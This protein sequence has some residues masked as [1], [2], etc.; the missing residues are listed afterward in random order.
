MT[1]SA[2]VAASSASTNTSSVPTGNSGFFH[3]NINSTPGG[4]PAPAVGVN[5]GSGG[6]AGGGAGV[7]NGWQGAYIDAQYEQFKADPASVAPDVRAFF[8]GFELAGSGGALPATG[9][10]SGDGAASRFQAAVDALVAAYRRLGHIGAKLDP[11]GRERARPESLSVAY[12][13]L[14]E[15]D[16]DQPVDVSLTGVPGKQATLREMVAH[17]EET[18]CG[19]LGV[20][21][22][23]IQ[24][25]AER[26]WFLKKFEGG[27]GQRKLEHD[28]KV[29]VLEE[30]SRAEGFER[31]LAKRYPTEKRF[32]L[33]GAESVI[34]LL[35]R[36]LEHSTTLGVEEVVIGM[37]HRGRLNVLNN[38]LGKSYEQIF[39]EFED[40]WSAGFADGG[41]DVKYHRG[42]SGERTFA[43]GAKLHVA[44]ASN[45][46][47]LESVDPV[48]CGRCR[49][50]QRLRGDFE[51]RRVIPL[52]IH[53]D[54]AIAGQGVVAECLNFGQ[55]EGYTV[56][57]TVHVVINNLIGFTT[58]P[59]D[60]R[61]TRYCTDVAKMIDAPVLHVNGEDPE[62]CIAAAE[63]AIEYRQMFRRDVMIDVWCYRKYGHNE[64]DEPSFTQPILAGL[65]RSKPSTLTRYAEGLAREGVV[66]AAEVEA[67]Q[68]RIEGELDEAQGKAKKKPFDPT[69]DPGS[70]RWAGIQGKYSFAPAKT[71][72]KAEV[73]REVCGA[74]GRTPEGF[75][76]NTKL[77]GL[78][79][80]R[81][82]LGEKGIISYADAEV[83]AIGTLLLEGIPV[84][85]SGQDC[86][87][88]TFT[89]RHA[90]LRDAETGVAYVPLNHMREVGQPGTD[91]PIGSAGSDGK[92][93]QARFCVYDSPLSEESVMGFDYG[94][95]L[96]D[97]NM[98]VCWE[99]QFGDFV[100]GAQVVI[101]QYL[102][103]SEA[104][105]D[106][107]SGLVLL[108]PH[109]YEGAGPEHSSGRLERF[110]A[111]C[112]DENMEVINPTTG[113][114]IFHALRRQVKRNFRK[115]LIVMT[116]KSLLR[117]ETSSVEELMSGSFQEV[118][119][120]PKFTGAFM[121]PAAGGAEAK[122]GKAG[123]S[124]ERKGVKRV[125]LCSGKVFWDLWERREEVGKAEVAVVRVEQYY[126]LHAKA[127]SAILEK[128]P[129]GAEKVWVQEEPRNAGAWMFVQ[130][131][132]RAEL[133]VE[134]R[135]IGRPASA[136]PAV[137]SKTAHKH[138]QD[139]ILTEAVGA[140]SKK[141]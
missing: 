97:P 83:L 76:V 19:T 103:S 42:Y 136:S 81:A 87:R 58:I 140:G 37:A 132:V 124:A 77:K 38:I 134:L 11:F 133:G 24:D 6:G 55:L 108:L 96:A 72:V 54:A 1:P 106:R 118:I 85:L 80:A 59:E 89:Q 93:R 67:V 57:G 73:L 34:P 64:Q 112:A 116:P 33:E 4:T 60:A 56:G 61:S 30:M 49:A 15:R 8:M 53:G 141:K 31:F 52:L 36:L 14:G 88:G 63:L 43:G 62:A 9:V 126:P 21:F 101:D 20:E 7:L 35:N 69:I 3:G 128:Y 135:Y 74:L 16:L 45:P 105:W 115:P 29:R 98:L 27:R 92:A 46:S 117:K 78:L 70:A 66:T 125:V 109:G 99:G 32:S 84:R 119:D 48:V 28:E 2:P 123:K 111:L 82:R 91:Q 121:P 18:Y 68:K 50:K 122:G 65:I 5:A 51:R 12:H 40:N 22:I 113:A 110:L 39:T 127:L 79:E 13:G 44:M 102:V 10:A 17:L 90:V 107:W 139:K 25:Q 26:E 131:A 86:R 23:H 100:N 94:Y 138:E 114:Q 129:K 137:G 75:G 47:H 95:S 41:G 71:G 104:K 130:D 120:D